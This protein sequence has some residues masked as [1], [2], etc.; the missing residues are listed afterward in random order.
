MT[1]IGLLIPAVL[2]LLVGSTQSVGLAILYHSILYTVLLF[3]EKYNFCLQILS[4]TRNFVFYNLYYNFSLRLFS[5]QCSLILYCTCN[6]QISSILMSRWQAGVGVD[7]LLGCVRLGTL[8]EP[9]RGGAEARGS[10]AHV[11]ALERARHLR[12]HRGRTHHRSAG[13]ALALVAPGVPRRRACRRPRRRHLRHARFRPPLH[14]AHY[15]STLK[16]CSFGFMR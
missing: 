7:V 15:C 6:S 9:R 3:F 2:T 10:L 13:A 5:F 16:Y 1:A 11:R 4:G 12:R 8:G 14:L